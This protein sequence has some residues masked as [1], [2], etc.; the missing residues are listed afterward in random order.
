MLNQVSDFNIYGVNIT[1]ARTQL[2][3]VK[4]LA[5]HLFYDAR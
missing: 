5:W 3:Y 2:G 4:I 1:D